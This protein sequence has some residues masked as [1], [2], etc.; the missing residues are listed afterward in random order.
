VEAAPLSGPALAALL[1]GAAVLVWSSRGSGTRRLMRL[2]RFAAGPSAAKRAVR[3]GGGRWRAVLHPGPWTASAG[4]GLATAVLLGGLGGALAGIVAA[5]AAQHVLSRLEPA[6]VRRRR[7]LLAG[8]APAAAELLAACL[9][10]GASL[11]DAIDATASAI[12]GP[13]AELLAAALASVRLGADPVRVWEDTARE[14]GIAPIARTLARAARGGAPAADVLL[15]LAEE[16]RERR[17]ADA[18]AAAQR[19]GVQ[20]VAPLAVC[21]LPAFVLL[22]VVPMVLSLVAELLGDLG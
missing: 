17:G 8:D 3:P 12:G 9:L 5:V 20:A 10:A 7:E 13:L 15:G 11:E 6:A 2:T 21:F 18:Q 14:P 16:M 19:V 22:G 4:L 1:A